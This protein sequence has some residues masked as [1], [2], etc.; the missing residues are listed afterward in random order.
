MSD[1]SVKDELQQIIADQIRE[2]EQLITVLETA[3]EPIGADNA[4]GRLS[5]MEALNAK[6]INEEALRMAR[7]R[8]IKLDTARQRLQEPDFG[9]CARCGK[10]IAVERLRLVPESRICAPCKQSLTK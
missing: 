6:S 4:I 8:L 10:P 9:I 1:M 3:T 7:E 5:R 2:A